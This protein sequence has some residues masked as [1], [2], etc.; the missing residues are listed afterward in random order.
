M[1]ACGIGFFLNTKRA[2]MTEEAFYRAF[3]QEGLP[4]GSR[5]FY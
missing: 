4:N 1:F 5:C 3:K 2:V